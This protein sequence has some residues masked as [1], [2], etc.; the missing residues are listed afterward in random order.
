MLNKKYVHKARDE[1]VHIK[2]IRRIIPSMIDEVTFEDTL[3]SNIGAEKFDYVTR[4][5]TKRKY[6]NANREAWFYK[7]KKDFLLPDE[8]NSD[9]RPE[10]REYFDQCYFFDCSRSLYV[11][12]PGITEIEEDWCLLRVLKHRECYVADDD[13]A[14][15]AAILEEIEQFAE[16]DA[17]VADIYIDSTHPYFFEHELDHIPGLLLLEAGRQGGTACYHLYGKVPLKGVGMMLTAMHADFYRYAE[18]NAPVGMAIFGYDIKRRKNKGYWTDAKMNAFI[19]QD[20]ARVARIH[21]AGSCVDDRLLKKIR[22]ARRMWGPLEE[23]SAPLQDWV[24][25]AGLGRLNDK[26]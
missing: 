21:V 8:L 12:R 5:F 20:G 4:F 18:L 3:R 7:G 9:L 16:E 2:A 26:E 10:Q 19:F 17:F 13:K 14:R 11:K 23:F 22:S 6:P 25:A 1:N 24:G 15:L